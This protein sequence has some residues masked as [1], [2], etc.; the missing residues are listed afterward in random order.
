MSARQVAIV[1]VILFAIPAPVFCL[2]QTKGVEDPAAVLLGELWNRT[3]DEPIRAK[4]L[5]ESQL[6]ANPNDENLQFAYILN[7]MKHYRFQDAVKILKSNPGGTAS[8]IE[9]WIIRT[10]SEA[11]LGQHDQSLA[12][13]REMKRRT[14]ADP[15][16]T[17]SELRRFYRHA[18]RMTGYF[19]GPVAGSPNAD[20]LQSTIEAIAN[21]A[22]AEQLELFNAERTFVLDRFEQL[23]KAEATARDAFLKD[24]AAKGAIESDTIKN[25]NETLAQRRDQVQPEVGRLTG[26]AN[27]KIAGLDQQAGPLIA[28]AN[29]AEAQM[30]QLSWNL[31]NVRNEI[32]FIQQA[33]ATEED[34]A[35]R[36]SLQLRLNQLYSFSRGIEYDLV[37][38][39]SQ[40]VGLQTQLNVMGVQRTQISSAYSAEIQQQKDE[41]NQLDRQQRKNDKR[42]M[43]IIDGPGRVTGEA[44]AL[45]N[46][47]DLLSTYYVLPL[48]LFRQDFLDELAAKN[49]NP[50]Q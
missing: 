4:S 39:R 40:L 11:V 44:S 10:W 5:G 2:M 18:G 1:A 27:A 45:A 48:E 17:D 50:A 32:F 34:P 47:K 25:N 37:A 30:N 43:D 26:E 8:R 3:G 33:L 16:L 23:S 9:S 35:I 29:A 14:Q 41:L 46:K 22:D 31:N 7:R 24:A 6:A 36:W 20:F 28:Q 42:L 15:P 13:L 12:S 49:R 21:G 19:Q 38:A